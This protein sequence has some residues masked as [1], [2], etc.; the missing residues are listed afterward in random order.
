[1]E[2][3]YYELDLGLNH[4]VRQWLESVDRTSTLLFQVPGGNYGSG[5]VL[6]C[7]E[8]NVTYRHSNQKPFRVPIPDGEAPQKIRSGSVLSFLG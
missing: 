2:L 1:M 5:G 7:G 8:E 4:V 3:V 6:V